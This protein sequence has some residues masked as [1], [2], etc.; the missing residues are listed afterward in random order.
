MKNHSSLV[1]RIVCATLLTLTLPLGVFAQTALPTEERPSTLPISASPTGEETDLEGL[2]GQKEAAAPA[3]NV[4][5]FDY[6]RFGSAGVML[7]TPLSGTIPGTPFTFIGTVNNTNPYPLVGLEVYVKIFKKQAKESDV[8]ANGHLLVDQFVAVPSMTIPANGS[9]PVTFI[10]NVPTDTEPG[11]YMLATYTMTNKQ[12]N[13]SG[14]SFTDDVTGSAVS[15][16]VRGKKDGDVAFDKNKVMMNDTQFRFAAYIPVF[17]KD[18]TVT[19]SVPL[20]NSTKETQTAHISWKQY[21]WDGLRAEALVDSKSESITLKPGETQEVSHA[22]TKVSGAVTYVVADATVG[23]AHSILDMR[24]AR[25][26]IEQARINFPSLASFPLKEGKEATVFSCLH[27]VGHETLPGGKLELLLT[28]AGGL[29]ITK[30]TYL[31]D[32]TGAMMGFA[33]KFTPTKNYDKVTLTAILSRGGVVE[34]T[35]TITY[36]CSVIDPTTCADDPSALDAGDASVPDAVIPSGS[37]GTILLVLVLVLALLGVLAYFKL[38]K[39]KVTLAVVF[40]AILIGASMGSPTTAE[41]KTSI[42]WVSGVSSEV[43]YMWIIPLLRPNVAWFSAWSL[44]SMITT[45]TYEANVYNNVTSAS[46]ADGATIPVGTVLRFAPVFQ[47][48]NISWVGTGSFND[49]PYGKWGVDGTADVLAFRNM[50]FDRDTRTA[51]LFSMYATL[52]APTPALSYIH[53]GTASLSCNASGSICTVN[54]AGSITST[55]RFAATDAVMYGRFTDGDTRPMRDASKLIARGCYSTVNAT[56]IVNAAARACDADLAAQQFSLTFPT[57]SIPFS[58]TA[59]AVGNPPNAPTITGGPGTAGVAIPLTFTAT[60]P[61]GDALHYEIDWDNDGIADACAPG[62]CVNAPSGTA[63]SASFTWG[64]AGTY[65]IRARTM[66]GGQ[67]SN[68]TSF[69]VTV[70]VPPPSVW[71]SF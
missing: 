17:T 70:T 25:S 40:L 39:G 61:D 31:G 60:D 68:W 36:D 56:L 4:N 45:V 59:I 34:E 2:F 20:T 32:I 27:V 19:I 52:Q 12:Y 3:G 8:L 53:S 57:Q 49:S 64:S 23:T 50:W 30:A 67:S 33:E 65:T 9:V 51:K 42:P 6:Y 35:G 29:T 37:G 7:S 54:S 16:T 46:I 11:E 15:F 10:W 22:V 69:S 26:G 24:F 58:F 14:L 62:T 44:S 71:L 63:Q 13:L 38:H 28:D 21:N 55:V 5:C 48:T 47:D 18:E 66:A 1:V 41:A 43:H